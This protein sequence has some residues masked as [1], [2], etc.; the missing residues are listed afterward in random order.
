MSPV[1]RIAVALML[2]TA[3][4]IVAQRPVAAE[5]YCTHDVC[6]MG[7]GFMCYQNYNTGCSTGC[8]YVEQAYCLDEDT[9]FATFV[10]S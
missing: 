6:E 8:A 5:P 7:A 4:M 9:C 10:C 3:A 2:A 1:Q